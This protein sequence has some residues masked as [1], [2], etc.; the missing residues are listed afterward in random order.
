MIVD[1]LLT[2]ESPDLKPGAVFQRSPEVAKRN[3]D[4]LVAMGIF[5]LAPGWRVIHLLQRQEDKSADTLLWG[6]VM[7][8]CLHCWVAGN[9]HPVSSCHTP[10]HSIQLN[11]ADLKLS[12]SILKAHLA[13]QFPEE[14]VNWCIFLHKRMLNFWKFSSVLI[15]QHQ[16]VFC[17]LPHDILQ[18]MQQLNCWLIWS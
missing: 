8:L 10:V 17:C 3:G 5:P 15:I 2:L 16:N 1:E 13:K 12:E 14:T 18:Q 11:A 4:G 6:A 9:W 7:R